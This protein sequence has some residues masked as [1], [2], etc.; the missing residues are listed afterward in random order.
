MHNCENTQ[1]SV[2]YDN[3]DIWLL[4][5]IAAGGMYNCENTQQSVRYDNGDIWLLKGIAVGGMYNCE[6]TQQSV[7]YDNGKVWPLK[8]INSILC[9]IWNILLM[10]AASL[11]RMFS[12]QVI[13]LCYVT[14]HMRIGP[15]SNI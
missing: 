8:G 15:Y 11:V 13:G 5:G 9:F 14:A 7:R 4:K 12:S 3:G 6:N 1:Q 10:P 2:R